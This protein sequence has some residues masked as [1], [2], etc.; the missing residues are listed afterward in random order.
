[1]DGGNS[2]SGNSVS[3]TDFPGRFVGEPAGRVFVRHAGNPTGE[4]IFF[5]HGLGGESLDWSDV[6]SLL[7]DRFDCYA[8]DLPGFGETPPPSDHDLSIDA[9]A[10]A[11]AATIEAIGKSPVHL[12]GNSLGGAVATRV[13]VEHPQQVRSLALISPALPDLRPNIWTAQL[14]VA[15][16][17][18][19]GPWIVRRLMTGRPERMAKRVI[20]V[21]FGSPRAITVQQWETEVEAIRRRS[22]LVHSSIVYRASLR[23]LVSEYLQRGRRRLWRQ[24]A[25]V[26]AR[27]LVVYGGRDKLVDAR[28]A[29]R[30]QRTFS[31]ARVIVM[32]DAGHVAQVEFPA[33]VAE[34]IETF[35]QDP[36]RPLDPGMTRRHGTVEAKAGAAFEVSPADRRPP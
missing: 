17:P 26:S 30:A 12:V 16:V 15:L 4:P 8:I 23:A 21:C 13:A 25:Q 27:T 5:V 20:A 6:A 10:G 11:V 9:H 22:G 32:P 2:G 18:I 28:M 24:A 14:L 36:A 3:T 31:N 34:L 1:M 29:R 33:R 35:T 19:V 7:A